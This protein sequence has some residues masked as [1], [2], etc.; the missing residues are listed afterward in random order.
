MANE[1][2]ILVN[3]D[4]IYKDKKKKELTV[5]G[6]AVDMTHKKNPNIEVQQSASVASSRV[7]LAPRGDVI[8]VYDLPPYVSVGFSVTLSVNAFDGEATIL[9]SNEEES[10][11]QIIDLGKSYPDVNQNASKEKWKQYFRKF[12]KGLGYLKRNGILNTYRRVRIDQKKTNDK[13][14]E[15]IEKN[16][17]P[18][19]T[20]VEIEKDILVSIVVPVYNVEVKWLDKCIQSVKD[21]TYT[22]WELCIADDAS[23]H[24]ELLNALAK[25][26]KED[27]RIKVVFRKENGHICRATNS[28]LEVA[29]GEFVALLDNDDELAPNA[30]Y[31]V[32]RLL[33]ERPELNLLYSD[34]DK[35][36]EVGTRS[37]PAFKPQ[38]SPDLLMS[39][40]YISH[41]GVYRRSIIEEIGGLRVGF[42]GAQ[43]YDLVLRFTE[44]ISSKTIAHIPKVLYHWRMLETSTAANQGSKNYAFQ[45]GQKALQEALERRSIDGTVEAGPAN[46]LYRVNYAIPEKELVSIIIPTRNGY[47]DL[48]RC[49]DSIIELTT[50]PNYEVIVAD[51]GSDEPQMEE[52]YNQY[53]TELGERFIKHSID[54]PFNFSKINNIAAK[55]AKGKYLLFLN[56]DT[57]VI[58]PDW[59]TNMV[60]LAQLDHVGTVGAKLYYE[61]NTIQHAGVIVGLGGVAGHGHHTYPKGDF[62]YFGRLVA[63]TDY[64]AVTAACV[65]IKK[66]DFE[67][68]D[69]FDEDFVVAYN[70]VDL[71]LRVYEELGKYNVYSAD[72][73]LYHYESQSRGYEDTP[74]KQER[75]LKEAERFRGKWLS[76]VEDDPFY[77]PNLTRNGGDFSVRL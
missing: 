48:K 28:A 1:Q 36:D 16:E 15:W 27:P 39:T 72:T 61:N 9:F 58:T 57:K 53:S 45:A 47:K 65:M 63:N 52:L 64:L 10:T 62:G 24:Q 75:F 14:L 8:E 60:S 33:N 66:T 5:M 77:N 13:Y 55:D 67:Q 29:T 59:L 3:I 18:F 49:I 17:R 74:E 20:S 70:D 21:Q 25:Y 4:N 76:Y 40:N 30:I 12:K 23:T 43:D 51:N 54:I 32:V 68:L 35:I 38:W 50:Y 69:G 44:M 34:E 2:K 19:D 71:C 11:T 56:N 31:E 26:E 73:E 37:D 42:E 41:L 46:G 22:N 7:G 6:W